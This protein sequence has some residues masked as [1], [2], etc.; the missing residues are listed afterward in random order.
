M[1][2]A[3]F[4]HNFMKGDGQGR[5]QYETVRRAHYLGHSVTIY[6]DRVAPDLVDGGVR[7]ERIRVLPRRPNLVGVYTYNAIADHML[8]QARSRYDV[9]LAAGFTLHEAHHVNLC[10]F[11]NAA[12][13]RSPVHVSKLSHGPNSW[14]QRVYTGMNAVSERGTYASAMR[15]V[16]PSHKIREEL[17]SIG[18]PTDRIR[19]IRNGVDLDEFSPRH[20]DRAKLGLPSGVPLALFC[21]DI[22]TARKNLDSVLRATARLQGI[23]LV[24]VGD[25]RRSPFPAMAGRLGIS[26][27]V[28]FMGFRRDVAHFMQCC[29]LFVFPSRYEAGT[30]VLIEA[31]ASGLPVITARTTGGAEI[32]SSD[33]GVVLDNP[34]DVDGLVAA[35]QTYL[36]DA[37]L[38]ACAG[39][40][41]REIATEQSWTSM[42]DEILSLSVETAATAKGKL[43]TMRV[44]V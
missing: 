20:V 4:A 25:E 19:V 22:R 28:H 35:M 23:H 5:I 15:V 18:V 40:R 2:I 29:D 14:Y 33:A 26:E 7:W 44:A 6:A 30:L 37:P 17:E 21:G 8:R 36:H 24:V 27:R 39:R 38:R 34:D 9:I 31:M 11:V 1:K 41:G 43:V 10:Q 42:A 12:W 3:F 32:V 16:A 13:L